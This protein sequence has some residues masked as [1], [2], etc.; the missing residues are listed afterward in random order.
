MND[1]TIATHSSRFHAD[2][3]FAVA[4]LMLL[5]DDGKTGIDIIRTRDM[6]E[7]E[8]AQYV[9]DVGGVYDPSRHLFDHHQKEG[10]GEHQQGIPFAAFGL[11]WK[12]Y[13]EQ[14]CA[15]KEAADMIMKRI[16]V[17]LDA[18]DNGI[19]L[20]DSRF[21]NIYPYDMA[22]AV[23]SFT[24]TWR[25]KEIDS[26]FHYDTMFNKVLEIAKSILEREIMHARALVEGMPQV[27]KLY[28]DAEDK[29][30]LV[31]GSLP[32]KEVLVKYPEPLYVIRDNPQDDTWAVVA[33][34]KGLTSFD[35][36]KPF[37]QQ[38]AGL[39]D[40]D[41]ADITGVEDA[42]FCHKN[43]FLAVAQTKEGALRLAQLAV[44]A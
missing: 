19:A 42:V 33:V 32:Y 43:L 8:T 18:W 41:L 44:N 40:K 2:D 24:A 22:L 30:I 5:L 20:C 7:I 34:R 23:D 3:V 31:V 39:R 12:E 29:R 13:G 26:D 27:E 6:K 17:P 36:R 10:A 9:V 21:E 14:L 25:E 4:T 15:S 16:V 38:W 11:V 1:I 28:K 35:M 37:P